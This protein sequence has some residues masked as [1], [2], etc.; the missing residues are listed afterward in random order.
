MA[1]QTVGV[2][3]PE[4]Q[5][6]AQLPFDRTPKA[7]GIWGDPDQGFVGSIDGK[8]L[9]DGYGV[10]W[11]PIAEV[12]ARYRRTEVLRNATAAQIAE[13]LTNGR[14]VI[15]WG[16]FGRYKGYSWQ[17]STDKTVQA[18]NGEHARVAV[19]FSGDVSNPTS[20]KI[21]DPIYGALTWSTEKFMEN[22]T[23]L[24]RHAVVVYPDSRWVQSSDDNRIWEISADGITRRWVKTWSAFQKRGGSAETVSEITADELAKTK[25]GPDIK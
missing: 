5:L 7:G 18:V 24:G 13:H 14:P 3:V 21:I 12:G 25:R 19:G 8:M 17:T 6:I 9:V 10:Y 15:I 2:N 20:F 4:S 22:W 16:Y 11:D 23:S 1:L